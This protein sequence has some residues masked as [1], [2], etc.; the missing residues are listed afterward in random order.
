[1]GLA[2]S[3]QYTWSALLSYNL[4]SALSP[5]KK[6]KNS[7]TTTLGNCENNCKLIDNQHEFV[8]ND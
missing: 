3:V 8:C 4:F 2:T 1:M 7:A 5:E 6:K